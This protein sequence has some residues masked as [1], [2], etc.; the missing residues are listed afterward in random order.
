MDRFHCQS[1]HVRLQLTGV[2]ALRNV[3]AAAGAARAPPAPQQQGMPGA[4]PSGHAG[5]RPF[6]QRHAPGALQPHQ[7]EESFVV[8]DGA[9]RGAFGQH[10]AQP[11]G[12]VAPRSLE[13]SFVMLT[14]GIGGRNAGGISTAALAQPQAHQQGL[15]DLFA[16]CART[17]ELASSSTQVDQPLCVE[18]AGKVVAEVDADTRAAEGE[19]AAYEAALARLQAEPDAALPEAEFQTRL[20][21]AEADERR[22]REKAEQAEAELAAAERELASLQEAAGQVAALEER[23][24]HAFNDLS[25]QLSTHLQDRDA[26]LAKI[27]AADAQLESLRRT[28]VWNDVFHI[29]HAGAFGTIGGFRLGRTAVEPVSWE[30]INAAWGHAVLLLHTLAQACQMTFS[31][32]RLLPMG[33]YPRVAD[34]RATHDL[35]GPVNRFV[36]TGYDRAQVAFLA[37]LKEFAAFARARDIAEKRKEAFELPY[38]IDGDRVGGLTIKLIFNKLDR[39]TKA[40]KYMLSDLKWALKWVINANNT[41]LAASQ[42]ASGATSRAG[43]VAGSSSVVAGNH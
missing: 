32:Y 8:L 17:F 26:T 30:E 7:M 34:G 37:C 36:C 40:L 15:D 10:A 18:C 38:A 16:T 13:E 5:P 29:W 43:S 25:L 11:T 2:E 1:C 35:Y 28:N 42:S 4:E 39:W 20:A 22:E 24:W 27:E 41:A 19:A 3:E 21:A 14:G 12:M 31:Q 9:Q 33:S 23:Y 6:T